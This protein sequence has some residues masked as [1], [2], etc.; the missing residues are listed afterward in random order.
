M[1]KSYDELTLP[2]DYIL[3]HTTDKLFKIESET[4]YP[5]LFCVFHPSEWELENV[6]KI[7]LK[8]DISLFFAI[9]FN[10][11]NELFSIPKCLMKKIT[12]T[13]F[14]IRKVKLVSDYLLFFSDKLK[15]NL[16]D[17]FIGLQKINNGNIEVCLI[18]NN[19]IFEVKYEKLIKDWKCE[20]INYNRTKIR[21][22]NWGL[23]YPLYFENT[24]LKVNENY[25]YYIELY[26]KNKLD[27][28]YK[29]NKCLDILLNNTKILYH[30]ETISDISWD[31]KHLETDKFRMI[32][33]CIFKNTF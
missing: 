33:K 16:F 25:K 15:E 13:D 19:E 4:N 28:K 8:R 17:G 3:Y 6:T 1:R 26:L 9:D 27:S 22:K 14:Y 23:N 10:I 32:D 29:F 5:M 12:K 18:N 24:I 20:A 21:E 11:S 2:K 31:V 30:K 7:I